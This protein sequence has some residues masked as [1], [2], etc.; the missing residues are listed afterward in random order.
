MRETEPCR[1]N[2]RSNNRNVLKAE[3][4]RAARDVTEENESWEGAIFLPD[5]R[6]EKYFIGKLSGKSKVCPFTE[7]DL[8]ELQPDAEHDVFELLINSGFAGKQWRM[9]SNAFHAKSKTYRI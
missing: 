2:A 6:R 5:T 9:R 1:M 4:S 7:T 3:M 8:I